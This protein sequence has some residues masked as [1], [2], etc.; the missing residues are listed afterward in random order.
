MKL[1]LLSILLLCVGTA[2][3]QLYVEHLYE[4]TKTYNPWFGNDMGSLTVSLEMSYKEGGD[5]VMTLVFEISQTK[6]TQ[7]AGSTGVSMSG[8]G[9]SG[10]WGLIGAL[11]GSFSTSKSYTL[12]NTQGVA[13]F[14]QHSYDSLIT[15]INKLQNISKQYAAYGKTVFF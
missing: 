1:F 13:M 7:V 14:D 8:G 6:A 11:A 5:S 9:S 10:S 3:S 2:S 12:S 4:T 15:I